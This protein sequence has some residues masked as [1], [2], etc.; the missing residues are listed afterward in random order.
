[1]ISAR[2]GLW[3]EHQRNRIISFLL[4]PILMYWNVVRRRRRRRPGVVV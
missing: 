3:K 4:I 2:F 1:M